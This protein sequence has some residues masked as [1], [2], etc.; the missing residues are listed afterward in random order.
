MKQTFHTPN[1]GVPAPNVA[2]TVPASIVP[3]GNTTEFVVTFDPAPGCTVTVANI[4]RIRVLAGNVAFIDV[5]LAA[6]N[7]WKQ[8]FAPRHCNDLGTGKVLSIP[9]AFLD[10][11]GQRRRKVCQVPPNMPISIQLVFGNY[12][13]GVAEAMHLTAIQDPDV[14]PEYSPL[15]IG[16]AMGIAA[17]LAN[18][19]YDPKM[20]GL[21]RAIIVNTVGLTGFS[22][23]VNGRQLYDQI[24]GGAL[25]GEE[26]DYQAADGVTGAAA[27]PV[28]VKQPMLPMNEGNAI[29]KLTT[30]VGVW[31]GAA[32]ELTLYLV[33]PEGKEGAAFQE[34]VASG[35]GVA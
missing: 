26:M 17:G 28:C 15:L 31:G 29:V 13:A 6:F 30:L 20:E 24:S 33:Q 21:L 19:V 23:I 8:R 22:M 32:N 5:G 11:K 10:E 2:I 12:V 3:Q 9:M 25:Y 27:D 34:K 16:N 7:A 4:A 18:R 35:A 14:A 1:V